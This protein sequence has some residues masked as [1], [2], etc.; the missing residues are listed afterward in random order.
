MRLNPLEEGARV[1]MPHCSILCN[2]KQTKKRNK[3][4][5]LEQI[6]MQPYKIIVSKRSNEQVWSIRSDMEISPK[7]TIKQTKRKNQPRRR[8]VNVDRSKTNMATTKTG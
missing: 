7:H 3:K 6:M 2:K 4:M 8:E 5:T 1:A